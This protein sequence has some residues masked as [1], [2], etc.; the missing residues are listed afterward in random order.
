MADRKEIVERFGR[1][2]AGEDLD[3]FEGALLIAQLIEPEEDTSLARER[4]ESLAARVRARREQGEPPVEALCRVLFWEEGFSGDTESYDAPENSSVARALA[5]HQGMPITLSILAV[6]VGRRA[7]LELAG[8]GL[9]GHFVVG[10]KDL[11]AGQ[12]LDPFDGGKLYN[13][14]ALTRRVGAIFGTPVAL[15]PEA[16]LPDGPRAILTRVL[17]N[18][19]RS[20]EKRNR[21]EEALLALE[22]AAALEPEEPAFL[23]ERGLLLLKV[24]RSEEAVKA[25]EKY[26]ARAAGGDA[27]AV[28]KLIVI[29]REQ[30]MPSERAQLLYAGPVEKKIFKL[31]EARALLPK[32]KELTT[33]AVSR[34]AR[35]GEGGE[36]E[37]E[38]QKIVGQWASTIASLGVEIKGLWLVD[39][40]SGAGYYC[41]KYPEESLDHFH[42]YEEGFSGRLPLQ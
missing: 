20:Y 39:F 13:A 21:L 32:V 6:E 18:L 7:G 31:E 22:C 30:T 1:F 17:F 27:E 14:E 11:P 19:R 28:G 3:L 23:R 38:R 36:A 24:G 8:I 35:L 15:P 12:Y 26:V 34:Y 29:V 10:G 42:G 41:W 33:D 9:P 37:E 25:L 5:R 16:L 40:D 2:A 4:V